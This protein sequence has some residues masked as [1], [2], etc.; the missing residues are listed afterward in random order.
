M[1][2]PPTYQ[3]YEDD[4]DDKII[5]AVEAEEDYYYDSFDNTKEALHVELTDSY[6]V[7]ISKKTTN[8]PADITRKGSRSGRRRFNQ[9]ARSN[10]ITSDT[11]QSSLDN[12]LDP[13][14]VVQ[15]LLPPLES[16]SSN[17]NKLVFSL[18]KLI[19]SSTPKVNAYNSQPLTF[20]ITTPDPTA[21]SPSFSSFFGSVSPPSPP[22]PPPPSPPSPPP[23]YYS[24]P[25]QSTQQP[26]QR[27]LVQSGPA[28]PSPPSSYY[29]AP[30]APPI[31][32]SAQFGPAP[33]SP[34]PSYY[35]APIAP[36]ISPTVQS[37][38]LLPSQPSSYYMVPNPSTFLPISPSVQSGPAPPSPPP[39]AHAPPAAA[40]SCLTRNT[41]FWGGGRAPRK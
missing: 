14:E 17:G 29:T 21:A 20:S 34:P 36:P 5:A 33:P 7:P 37:G 31:S 32:P 19:I 15:E 1:Q 22:S 3:D 30:I 8:R 4:E 16:P 28:P 10:S 38:S 39:P 23:S 35:T 9:G 11:L 25:T 13:G 41:W 26:F 24:A 18:P 27:P 6:G 40:C 12:A 2:A